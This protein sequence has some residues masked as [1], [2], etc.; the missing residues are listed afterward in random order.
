MATQR[1]GKV[2][3]AV[4]PDEDIRPTAKYI[5]NPTE[6]SLELMVGS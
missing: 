5:M 6:R 2:H 1:Y 4:A 3:L